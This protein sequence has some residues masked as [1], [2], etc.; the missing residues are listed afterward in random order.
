M[1][2]EQE[3]LASVLLPVVIGGEEG[4]EGEELAGEEEGVVEGAM[5]K[6]WKTSR[7]WVRRF[8]QLAEGVDRSGD[9]KAIQAIFTAIS[10]NC[11]EQKSV[12]CA[13]VYVLARAMAAV[14]VRQMA[15]VR[16]QPVPVDADA[17]VA[18]REVDLGGQEFGTVIFSTAALSLLTLA[19]GTA[20]AYQLFTFVGGA[21]FGTS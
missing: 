10:L 15:I 7:K 14:N 8:I 11:V 13:A 6:Q 19:L 21:V 1:D 3:M 4:E 2:A 17:A 18:L 20:I 12:E 5:A 9:L 16:A